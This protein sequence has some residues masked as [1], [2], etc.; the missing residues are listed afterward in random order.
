MNKIIARIAYPFW[1]V[2][3]IARLL[4]VDLPRAVYRGRK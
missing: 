4:L 3:T 2:A 1:Y